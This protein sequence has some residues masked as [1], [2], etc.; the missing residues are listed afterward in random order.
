MVTVKKILILLIALVSSPCLAASYYFSDCSWTVSDTWT[1]TSDLCDVIL[2]GN[3]TSPPATC[4]R[5]C[6]GTFPTIICLDM[7][8]TS[9][10]P[11][12]SPAEPTPGTSSTNPWCIQPEPLGKR[13]AFEQI[14]DY[15]AGATITTEVTAGDTIY[16]CA[17][18]CDG[19]GE[20]TWNLQTHLSNVTE[21]GCPAVGGDPSGGIYPGRSVF[22][23]AAHGPI[24]IQPYCNSDGQCET[25]TISGDSDGDNVYDNVTTGDAKYMINTA[26]CSGSGNGTR[27]SYGDYT[28]DGDPDG[29]SIPNLIVQDSDGYI[30]YDQGL[31]TGKT[32]T[33]T[34]MELRYQGG[35][36]FQ[37]TGNDCDNIVDDGVGGAVINCVERDSALVAATRVIGTVN[38][39]NNKMHHA[40]YAGVRTNNNCLTA[41]NAP[42]TAT[43]NEGCTS[44]ITALNVTG[45]TS[46]NVTTFYNS[47]Q[48]R[49]VTID[50]NTITDSKY[51]IGIEEQTRNMT[52]TD[53]IIGCT[54]QYDTNTGANNAWGK[55]TYGIEVSDGDAPPCDGCGDGG[56]APGSCS[57]GL[58]S[59]NGYCMSNDI[60]IARNKVFQ[61]GTGLLVTGIDWKG[62]GSD[63]G[64]YPTLGTSKI[65]NNM[66]W[67]VRGPCTGD[68]SHYYEA[69]LA[70]TSVD[71]LTL[72]N[73]TVYNGK[74]QNNLSGASHTFIDNILNND[75]GLELF[76]S[77]SAA[78]STIQYNNL[79]DNT[80]TIA[81][82]N[83]VSYTCGGIDGA[84]TGNICRDDT[85]RDVTPATP[86]SWDLR[87]LIGTSP[88]I[89]SGSG[90]ATDDLE[91]NTRSDGSPDIGADE[92]FFTGFA[93]PDPPPPAKVR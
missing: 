11:T 6:Y 65:E 15:G 46:W 3:F 38:I 93:I 30:F 17:G 82:I 63:A 57:N 40:C 69:P 71:S 34:G 5:T 47:H 72:Q 49:N 51:G 60:T 7:C 88:S 80:G 89:N 67:N 73:N 10:L 54:G 27:T 68:A 8:E 23:Y 64:S 84:G 86:A 55:C 39:T 48:I 1:P 56:L 45:N 22:D 26:S 16:L 31:P 44:G 28:W 79:Y 87:F 19:L 13:D 33:Y 24:T 50:G 75:D 91:G 43:Q 2:A 14:M 52:V 66:I 70:T 41:G 58:A 62:H 76:V 85:F 29:D 61:S 35:E 90:G 25:V 20:A 18:I 37:C 4:G 53:N 92:W 78:G 42:Y 83:G 36:F 21:Q 9:T 59:Q 74:C 77:A 12:C 81:T 32:N